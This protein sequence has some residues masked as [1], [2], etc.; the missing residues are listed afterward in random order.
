MVRH[1]TR[2]RVARWVRA[3]VLGGA[4]VV[5]ATMSFEWELG[6]ELVFPLR[7]L[8]MMPPVAY[9]LMAAVVVRETSPL[10]C[11]SW[12]MA[13]CG[14]N[15]A[16]GLAT[17]ITLSLSH[18]LSFEGA[19]M[20]AFGTFVPAPL[21]HL[22]TA[23]LVLLALPRLAMPP[24]PGR[25]RA[26][27]LRPAAAALMIALPNYD[28]V[29]R[30]P[31]AGA[32]SPGAGAAVFERTHPD[33]VAPAATS[34]ML[35]MP[36]VVEATMAMPTRV[37]AEPMVHVAFDR[38]ATQLPPEVFV[39][40]PTPRSESRLEPHTL[41]VPRRL[42]IPQLAE[43]RVE[44]P[45]TLLEDQVPDL[46]LAMPRSEIHRRFPDWVFSLPMDEVVSQIPTEL[47]RLA[48]P[49]ADLSGIGRFPAPFQ[50][51]PPAPETP[52]ETDEP[53]VALAPIPAPVIKAPAVDAMPPRPRQA[54]AAGSPDEELVAL[55]QGLASVLA[56]VPT[57]E[58]QARRIG[59]R[60]LVCFASPA[61]DRPAIDALAAR[62]LTL[63]DRL[64]TWSIEQVTV[65]TART[66]CVMTPLASG[67]VLAAAV[68]R[69]GPV[70]MLE[71]LAARARGT[72]G[73]GAPAAMAPPSTKVKPVA[74]G[75]SG[76][77]GEAARALEVFGTLVPAEAAQEGGAPAVYIFAGR[78]DAALAGAAR[79]VHDT[80]VAR[81]DEAALGRLDAVA[82]RRGRERVIVRPLQMPAGAPAL[83]AAAGEVTL[84][85]RAQRAAARAA[86]LLE[87]R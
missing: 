55:A 57:L 25:G 34:A 78:A 45:W 73:R 15:A 63:L 53:A 85:G 65:R 3:A 44:I 40:P 79:V 82:L 49:A 54:A 5:T 72:A 58:W 70:A 66:A 7:F 29:L 35:D 41:V 1:R 19:V 42:V 47:I 52:P 87:A 37:P 6:R 21:I 9:L 51:G 18:P 8:A 48:G 17:A 31:A 10:R 22:V 36:V 2:V 77:V 67:G 24:H 23:P 28:D 20:R 27:S 33:D 43:G 46:A 76:R 16:L 14:V 26:S 59:G 80:L 74:D 75:R 11:L 61:L 81:H 71:I 62:G 50:P 60:P 84:A 38:L 64:A 83:L 86:T 13:A 32:W 68:H 4:A 56:P 12:A 39:L 30:P 69:G